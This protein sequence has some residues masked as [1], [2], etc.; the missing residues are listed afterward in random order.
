[1][2]NPDILG[3]VLREGI[4]E[5]NGR[6]ASNGEVEGEELYIPAEL[7]SP[8]GGLRIHSSER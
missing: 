1:M 4:L 5:V 8:L 7:R 6:R 2:L 3:E